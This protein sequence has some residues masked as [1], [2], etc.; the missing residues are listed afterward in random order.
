MEREFLFPR[1]SYVIDLMFQR[2]FYYTF[3]YF[4]LFFI[5]NSLKFQLSTLCSH[6]KHSLGLCYKQ[7]LFQNADRQTDPGQID[8]DRQ[9]IGTLP[10]S[11]PSL[12]L[13]VT[14][15]SLSSSAKV[16]ELNEIHT[17]L[18][19]YFLPF[20]PLIFLQSFE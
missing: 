18:Q 11:L 20:S 4:I 7:A 15:V 8:T 9:M 13:C 3:Y 12:F 17:K 14:C 6:N 10:F 19:H 5:L 2:G 16:M 1:K